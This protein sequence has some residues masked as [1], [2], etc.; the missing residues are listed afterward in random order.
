MNYSHLGTNIVIK[1]EG[2][3]RHPRWINQIVI[4]RRLRK[5]RRSAGGSGQVAG[6]P[7]YPGQ[8]TEAVEGQP[9]TF[10]NFN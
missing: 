5:M 8:E 3:A 9:V 2:R 7:E 1:R 6:I 4:Q 10:F